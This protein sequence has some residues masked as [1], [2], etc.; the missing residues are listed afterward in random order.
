MIFG[1]GV[2]RRIVP[3]VLVDF[4]LRHVRH[5]VTTATGE[6]GRA[7][8]RTVLFVRRGPRVTSGVGVD[9]VLEQRA[10]HVQRTVI[11][12]RVQRVL[13]RQQRLVVRRQDARRLRPVIRIRPANDDV[14]DGRLDNVHAKGHSDQH[15]PVVRDFF[16]LH[17]SLS[18]SF[19]S[20]FVRRV[21]TRNVSS[22]LPGFC[23]CFNFSERFYAYRLIIVSYTRVHDVIDSFKYFWEFQ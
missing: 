16:V 3:V 1:N 19:N 20:R 8:R 7:G 5:H 12:G 17:S 14:S 10:Y 22:R 11:D 2:S 15:R 6:H 13:E 9:A 21:E 23:F 4:A 18:V